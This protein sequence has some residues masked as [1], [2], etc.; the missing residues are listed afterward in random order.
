MVFERFIQG[1]GFIRIRCTVVLIRRNT[2][3]REIIYC[4]FIIFDQD[5]VCGC[6]N[7]WACTKF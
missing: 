7:M 2:S 1:S 6:A 3:E 5:H 4:K